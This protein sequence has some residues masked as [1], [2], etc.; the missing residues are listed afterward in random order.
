M[1]VEV[2]YQEVDVHETWR[3]LL[4]EK[5]SRYTYVPAGHG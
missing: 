2:K 4:V 3:L 5:L 1:A